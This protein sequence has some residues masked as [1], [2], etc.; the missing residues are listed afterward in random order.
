MTRQKLL[1]ASLFVMLLAL[2]GNAQAVMT[3]DPETGG[4]GGGTSTPGTGSEVTTT[5]TPNGN[6]TTTTTYTDGSYVSVTND[7]DGKLVSKTE[8]DAD[9]VAKTTYAEG[10]AASPEAISAME[11]DLKDA[12]NL[13]MPTKDEL[14]GDLSDNGIYD[15]EALGSSYDKLMGVANGTATDL[16][17][18]NMSPAYAKAVAD[19]TNP[20][21]NPLASNS[22]EPPAENT[23]LLKNSTTALGQVAAGTPNDLTTTLDA[24]TNTSAFAESA[25][26][27]Q[28]TASGVEVYMPPGTE[29]LQQQP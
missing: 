20:S 19:P 18:Q 7:K 13:D 5:T 21:V 15:K 22:V 16:W 29:H 6:V 1:S 2:S 10:S 3:S 23:A 4:G 28:D 14:L 27:L 26:G 24:N 8:V 12:A 11:A 25:S 17:S 9:G